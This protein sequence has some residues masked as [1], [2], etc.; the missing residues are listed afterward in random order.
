M[1]AQSLAALDRIYG[2][3]GRG[4]LENGAGLKLY[5]T[6]RDEQHGARSLG[7]R[8]RVPPARR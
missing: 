2:P 3:E 8:R 4:S 5:I 7:R 1:I 6:P